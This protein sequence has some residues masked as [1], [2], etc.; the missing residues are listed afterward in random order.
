MT[1]YDVIVKCDSEK[2]KALYEFL[3]TANCKELA[4]GNL[5]LAGRG[6]RSAQYAYRIVSNSDK[7]A[8]TYLYGISQY[9]I[10]TPIVLDKFLERTVKL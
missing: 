6:L 4:G 3:K 10:K 5:S 1:T 2:A 9:E 7:T 8:Y